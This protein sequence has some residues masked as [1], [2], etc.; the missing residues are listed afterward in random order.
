MMTEAE[1]MRVRADLG[2]VFQ[3]GALFDSLTVAQNVGYKLYEEL[4]WGEREARALST[5]PSSTETER[6]RRS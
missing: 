4:H 1:L 2:M 5:L 3:E 6:P